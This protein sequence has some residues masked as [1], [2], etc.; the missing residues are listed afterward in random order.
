MKGLTRGNTPVGR[1]LSA[2]KVSEEK[3]EKIVEKS[4]ESPSPPRV[5][6]KHQ[7]LAN[8]VEEAVR[9]AQQGKSIMSTPAFESAI[10]KCMS[11][12]KLTVM[13]AADQE[14]TALR[15]RIREL[16]AEIV[17]I[18]RE[19]KLLKQLQTVE[20]QVDFERMKISELGEPVT[21]RLQ[22][23]QIQN[24]QV[25]QVPHHQQ[26]HQ[27]TK[28]NKKPAN[29]QYNEPIHINDVNYGQ[30]RNSARKNVMLAL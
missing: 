19:N 30:Y 14:Y 3:L 9:D 6:P 27:Q 7:N 16:E 18:K 17:L 8:A 26:H 12:L 4:P 21:H 29:Y 11:Q 28:K 24:V 22:S 13:S 2:P 25:Q 10:E 23:N 20:Q 15:D 5:Q 1:R